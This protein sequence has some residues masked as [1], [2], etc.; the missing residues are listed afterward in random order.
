EA[1]VPLYALQAIVSGAPEE[2]VVAAVA[3]QDIIPCATVEKVGLAGA[4]EDIVAARSDQVG[5]PTR[6]PAEGVVPF[7]ADPRDVDE[8][9]AAQ[10]SPVGKQDALNGS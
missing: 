10:D 4:L 5:G 1:V 9:V 6:A 7:R 2:R 3:E 8:R